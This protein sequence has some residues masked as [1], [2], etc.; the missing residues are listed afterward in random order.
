MTAAVLPREMVRLPWRARS[1]KAAK[2]S[3]SGRESLRFVKPV[4]ANPS[5]AMAATPLTMEMRL[6]AMVLLSSSPGS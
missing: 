6:P 4:M 3:L 5:P 2:A 1:P